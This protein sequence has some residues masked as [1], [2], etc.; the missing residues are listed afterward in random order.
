MKNNTEQEGILKEMADGVEIG[1][2]NAEAA[3]IES[4]QFKYLQHLRGQF[5][6]LSQS[7]SGWSILNFK[8]VTKIK[9]TK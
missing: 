7:L 9:Q 1:G 5:S 8:F 3:D 2:D 4:Y 6:L